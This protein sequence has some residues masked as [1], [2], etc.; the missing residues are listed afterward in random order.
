[1]SL[2]EKGQV[3]EEMRLLIGIDLEALKV[4]NDG[5]LRR[6]ENGHCGY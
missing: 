2:E 3:F 5:A 6:L 4:C 1:M